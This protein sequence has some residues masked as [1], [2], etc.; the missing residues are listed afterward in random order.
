MNQAVRQ[1]D[2]VALVLFVIDCDI[3]IAIGSKQVETGCI[4]NVEFHGFGILMGATGA[5]KLRGRR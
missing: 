4:G 5:L 3:V 2:Q 1:D